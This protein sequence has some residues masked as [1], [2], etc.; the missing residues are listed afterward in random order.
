MYY[1]KYVDINEQTNIPK[2]NNSNK[3][4]DK[5]KGIKRPDLFFLRLIII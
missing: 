2:N 4:N 1:G 3:K 5:I